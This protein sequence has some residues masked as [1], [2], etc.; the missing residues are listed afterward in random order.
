MS[1]SAPLPRNPRV[2]AA[3]LEALHAAAFSWSLRMCNR[4]TQD[5]E[6]IL[7]VV[8]ERIIDGSAVFEAR[9]SLR[10][11][12]FGVIARVARDQRRQARGRQAWWARWFGADDNEMTREPLE[13]DELQRRVQS[14]LR[15]L[16]PRQR[17]VLELVFYRDFT[18]EEA[19]Q[20]I[21]IGLGSARTHYARGKLALSE[22]LPEELR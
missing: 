7:Q 17:E 16:A 22:M 14:A 15:R 1:S 4:Q 8:Y 21:G 18:I 20:I 6:D 9:S 11:W 19:A 10:T 12:L 3:E 2:S 13:G 5:A